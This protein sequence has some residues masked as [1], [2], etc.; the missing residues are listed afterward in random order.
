MKVSRTVLTGEKSEIT[1]KTY[2]SELKAGFFATPETQGEYIIKLL[3]V[4]GSGVWFD[5]LA[6]RERF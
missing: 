1:S 4:E 6:E 2:L 3:N 5:P